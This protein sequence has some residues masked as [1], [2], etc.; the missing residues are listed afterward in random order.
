[1]D[2]NHQTFPFFEENVVFAQNFRSPKIDVNCVQNWN[3]FVKLKFAVNKYKQ[4]KCPLICFRIQYYRFFNNTLDAVN[5]TLSLPLRCNSLTQI[6]VN[7][8]VNL[9]LTLPL[10]CCLD[11]TAA[12]VGKRFTA[13]WENLQLVSISALLHR[14]TIGIFKPVDLCV[15]FCFS[16]VTDWWT[17]STRK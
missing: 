2:W 11:S 16:K 1:M 14:A 8:T 5:L 9:I 13:S 7:K 15:E 6:I 10:L 12:N 3:S 4:L 17:S